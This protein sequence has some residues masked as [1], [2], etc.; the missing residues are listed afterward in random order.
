MYLK[1]RESSKS[2]NLALAA[3]KE[4]QKSRR[5]STTAKALLRKV[6]GVSPLNWYDGLLDD[7]EIDLTELNKTSR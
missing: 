5:L 7:F 6:K 4:E 3:Y 2:V 1:K